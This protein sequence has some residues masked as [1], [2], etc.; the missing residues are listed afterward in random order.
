MEKSKTTKKPEKKIG[1]TLKELSK[2]VS[3]G[4]ITLKKHLTAIVEKLLKKAGTNADAKKLKEYSVYAVYAF[5]GFLMSAA[6][7]PQ[8]IKPLGIS[9]ICAFS[10]KNSVLFTYIGASL[11]CVLYGN[12]ALSSFIIYFMLY[13]VRKTFTE[14][15][16]CER[17]YVRMAEAAATSAV[18]GI[19]RIC[20]AAE[21]VIYSFAAALS[22]LCI[23]VAYTY[24]FGTLFDKKE[25]S[26]AKMS[27]VS[28]CSYALM[29]A[30]IFSLDGAYFLG[31][32]LQL[33][34][35][36]L[37]TLSYAVINGFL[38]SGS[39]GFICGIA[40]A[41]PIVS[42]AL[43][44]SGIVSAF[45]LTKSVLASA[46]AFVAVFFSVTVYSAGLGSAAMLLPSVIC[47]CVLFFPICGLLPEAFRL[48]A[49]AAQKNEEKSRLP[50][51]SGSHGKKLS[52][53]FFSISEMF[54]RLSEKSR[55]P[56]YSDVDMIVEKSFSQVCTGCAL[57]EMC[58]A[59]KKTDMDNLKQTLFAVLGT[60]QAQS[61]DFGSNMCEKCIRLERHIDIVNSCY[62]DIS[63]K[64]AADNRPALL[65]A[66]YAG[67]AR[68]MGDAE[69]KSGSDT[70]RDEIFEKKLADALKDADIPFSY[71]TVHSEREKKTKV[72]GICIDRIPYGAN[73]LKKYL[74]AKLNV[75]ITEPSFDI[76]KENDYVMS[77]SRA[78]LLRFEYAKISKS[79]NDDTVN[80]DT[81][82]FFHGKDSFFRA[83]ICDGMGS[84]KEAAV[85]SRL[86]SLFM[87]KML[88]TETDKGIILELLG[89]ALM[90]RS[91]ESFSTVDL[92]E[93]DMLTGKSIFVKAGAAPSYVIRTGKLYKIF[94]ATPPVGIISGF[95]SEIT[96]FNI[97]KGDVIVMV[98]DGAVP[99]NEDN[100][101][102][103][104][105]IKIDVTADVSAIAKEISEKCSELSDRSDDISI[106]VI[107]ALPENL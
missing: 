75:R 63:C 72:H 18:S 31:F 41:S 13:A 11:G 64:K 85:S 68:L 86:A 27:T 12:D 81:V 77:F 90:S 54:S 84:G 80:G 28:I 83:L 78:S 101:F 53:A 60:R 33:V 104:H 100:T 105:L 107:K 50:F 56:S 71:I 46:A 62:K 57:S 14:S 22:S 42:A 93:A 58:F 44:L 95:T 98:S 94:S 43:G 6:T 76:S 24:F 26:S 35:A 106:C 1:N 102:I 74:Y 9:A 30:I 49:C 39:I 92:L 34:A 89:N 52:E 67:M 51:I 91:E 23:S 2:K 36:C 82:S 21:A 73:E 29:A 96:R 5:F 79:I 69:N 99:N 97:E 3:N 61:E 32:N 19:I 20:S 16:F 8:S 10:D 40:S 37:I 15:K 4:I 17:L 7:L 38:H 25:Y 65:G 48:N 59:R 87:E 103:A 66:Q 47:G 70:K 45:L 88:E 55:Y